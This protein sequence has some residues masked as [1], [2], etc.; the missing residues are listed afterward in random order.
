M[1]LEVTQGQGNS[2]RRDAGQ[3]EWPFGG[4]ELYDESGTLLGYYLPPKVYA[5]LAIPVDP[6][7][8]EEELNAPIDLSDPGRPL[9][10]I[11]ADLR[12]R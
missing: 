8:T 10:D 11:L 3:A 5:S 7:F 4:L 6:P 12:K 1:V 9:E 2:R